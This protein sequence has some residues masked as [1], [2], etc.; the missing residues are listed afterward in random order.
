MRKMLFRVLKRLIVYRACSLIVP[1]K[2][3]SVGEKQGY[4][5]GETLGLPLTDRHTS[6]SQEV[7]SMRPMGTGL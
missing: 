4:M 2:T 7:Q 5:M 3:W 1:S 6:N